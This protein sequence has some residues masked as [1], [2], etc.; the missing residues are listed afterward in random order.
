MKLFQI[1]EACFGSFSE[2]V[3]QF[4]KALFFKYFNLIT[5]LNKPL[6][7]KQC[8]I[9]FIQGAILKLNRFLIPH[10]PN[11]FGREICSQETKWNFFSKLEPSHKKWNIFYLIILMIDL[12]DKIRENQKTGILIRTVWIRISIPPKEI[13]LNAQLFII[14][15][16]F[17]TNH[18]Q[19]ST[20]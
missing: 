8:H 5:R 20:L 4:M 15:L 13:N 1:I 14:L 9:L 2:V 6:S 18:I 10:P 19:I 12:G 17:F 7:R 16:I 3:N 11:T